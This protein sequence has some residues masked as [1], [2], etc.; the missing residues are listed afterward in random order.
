MVWLLWLLETA[1]VFLLIHSDETVQFVQ[2]VPKYCLAIEYI[3]YK[4]VAFPQENVQS[5]EFVDVS[6]VPE[7]CLR[8]ITWNQKMLHAVDNKS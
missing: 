6:S 8:G 1:F 5:V 3:Q 7:C 2:F 4:M